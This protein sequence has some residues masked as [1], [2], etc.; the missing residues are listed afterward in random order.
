MAFG[1]FMHLIDLAEGRNSSHYLCALMALLVFAGYIQACRGLMIA[2]ICVGF[3]GSIFALVG[4]KCTKI[5][6]SDR[7]KGRTACFA[8]VNFILSGESGVYFSLHV[9]HLCDHTFP[10]KFPFFPPAQAS[11]H[12]QPTPSTRTRLPQSSSTRCLWHRSKKKNN[13]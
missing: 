8:G 10:T 4:M 13:C 5:G 3:S 2:A 1:C 12:S 6:G 7:S 9:R 11:A